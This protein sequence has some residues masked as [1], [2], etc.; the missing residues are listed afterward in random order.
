MAL[1]TCQEIKDK[2]AKLKALIDEYENASLELASGQIQQYSFDSGQ[3]RQTVTQLDM[4]RLDQVIDSL[5]N[6]LAILQARHPQ[7]LGAGGSS[8]IV[9]PAW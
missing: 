6:R 1:Y 4:W 3:T 5:Y 9:R 8:I 7:C 2:A